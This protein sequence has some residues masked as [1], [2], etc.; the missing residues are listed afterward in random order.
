VLRDAG[1]QA[2]ERSAGPREAVK[3]PEVRAIRLTSPAPPPSLN[4]L[5][6]RTLALAERA[7]A[8]REL[9]FLLLLSLLLLALRAQGGSPI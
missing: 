8:G 7:I 1:H 4:G 6:P 5:M 2:A 9:A 3:W